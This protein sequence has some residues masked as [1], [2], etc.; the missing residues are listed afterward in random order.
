MMKVVVVTGTPG[1]GKTTVLNHSLEVVGGSYKVVNFGDVMIEV[2]KRDGIVEDRDDLRKQEPEVQKEI[3]RQAG[4]RIAEMA[5]ESN[6]I[7]DT[8]C[9][10]KTPKGY[11]PGLPVWVLEELRPDTII[12]V[13]A[14]PADIV[15]RRVGDP[16]RTRDAEDISMLT[17]HQEINRAIAVA[18]SVLTGATVKLVK[19][20]TDML[21]D[22]AEDMAAAMR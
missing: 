17:E 22:A 16:T 6:I 9:T 21:D 14:D 20:N 4:K 19:N 11:L 8:H 13:E 18:Y 3:Q 10:I 7:V 12:L 5:L 2:A 15:S 1:V